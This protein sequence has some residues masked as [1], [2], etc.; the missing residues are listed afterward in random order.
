MNADQQ[1][2]QFN[3][4]LYAH[5]VMFLLAMLTSVLTTKGRYVNLLIK[6][7]EKSNFYLIGGLYIEAIAV[8]FYLFYVMNVNSS[9]VLLQVCPFV[10]SL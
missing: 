5:L 1:K 10:K 4:C 2:L 8:F 9:Y 3:L 6:D 7:P